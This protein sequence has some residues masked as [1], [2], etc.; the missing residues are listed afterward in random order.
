MCFSVEAQVMWQFNK[1]TV[2]TWQYSWGDEFNGKEI[3]TVQWT[4]SRYGGRSIYSNKEQQY[5][6]NGKNHVL[7]NGIYKIIV[8]KEGIDARTIDGMED[9]DS[10]M[11]NNKFVQLN[12]A[13]FNYTSEKI[14]SRRLFT[15]GFFEIRF[16]ASKDRGMWPAFW[17]YGGYP[18]EEIDI[19]ELKGE[20]K[21]K[22]H[23][24]THC[25]NDCD[26][27]RNWYFA[28]QDWG[29]WIT[30]KENLN[31]GFNVMSAEWQPDYIKFFMNGKCVAYVPVNF[32]TPKTLQ[33]NVALP[34][35]DGPFHPGP[36]KD[37]T[38]FDPF[39][40]DYVRVWDVSQVKTKEKKILT[41]QVKTNL[42]T[43]VEG[44]S[45]LKRKDGFMYGKKSVH[46]TEGPQVTIM[47]SS[48][49][50][51][52]L[53]CTGLKKEMKVDL[54]L[55]NNDNKE[56]YST[57]INSFQTELKF[58]G[59]APGTYTLRVLCNGKEASLIINL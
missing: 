1:D 47:P 2:I 15:G 27:F 31:E 13:H 17:L 28:K 18:N 52:I 24:D 33:V 4:Y 7:E 43:V 45:G 19:F 54:K 50:N 8:K 14:E 37:M 35:D 34:A 20:R 11:A 53:Y 32:K 22:V 57:S 16:K 21:N 26:V 29:G 9:N 25:G 55:I 56:V 44:K 39:E 23:I 40:V 48:A 12:K 41:E 38:A 58:A 49:K 42:S 6:T 10:L 59:M 51:Y 5:Y 30:M 46:K 36:K 3:D